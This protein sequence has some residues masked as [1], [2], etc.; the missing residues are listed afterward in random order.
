MDR[1]TKRIL[2]SF[3][4]LMLATFAVVHGANAPQ[5]VTERKATDGLGN[6]PAHQEAAERHTPLAGLP[7]APKE[8]IK[9]IKALPDNTWLNL[10]SPAA[11]PKWG[12]GRGRSW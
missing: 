7:S 1:T 4:V 6:Q 2:V 3:T 10:Q 12:K 5:S 8:H 11:D 9:R